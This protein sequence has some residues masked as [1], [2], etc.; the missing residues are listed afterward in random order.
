MPNALEVVSL[1]LV[2]ALWGCTNPLLR[3]GAVDTAAA[4]TST[5]TDSTGTPPTAGGLLASLHS[6]F[7][8]L[9]HVRVWLPYVVNQ[10]GSLLYYFTLANSDLSLAVPICN[11]LALVFSIITSLVLGEPLR[12][13]WLTIVG[14]AM[15]VAGVTLC[16]HTTEDD[17]IT[18]GDGNDAKGTMGQ[19]L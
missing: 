4:G 6:F 18:T 9:S 14:S 16:L 19:E 1:I 10:C 7:R 12:R 13:P 15:V 8:Q 11:A 5:T 17:G 3:Q 2:G